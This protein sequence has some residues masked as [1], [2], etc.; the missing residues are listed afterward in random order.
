MRIL[1][2]TAVIVFFSNPAFALA[3]QVSATPRPQLNL[4]QTQAVRE[5][6]ANHAIPLKSVRAGAGFDDLKMLKSVLKNV[7]IVGLG[8]ASHGQREFFQ[9]KHRMLEFL[10][11]R[12][13]F[14]AFGI[15]ASY[16]ACMNINEYV[17][18]GKG[19]PRKALAS[20]GF[21][22][23]DTQ[24]ILDMVE[25]M[26]QY[27]SKLPEAKRIKFLGY[28]MQSQ[29]QY[30]MDAVA[31][32]LKK[33]S[34]DRVTEAET[35]FLPVKAEPGKP[36]NITAQSA[37]DQAKSVARLDKLH[38]FL[39][40]NR[41]KFIEQ[42]SEWDFN[43]VLLHTRVLAQGARYSVAS[44][45]GVRKWQSDKDMKDKSVYSFLGEAIA[46]R[47]L[48]MAENVETQLKMLG[49]KARMVIGGHNAHL[50]VGT[51]GDGNPGMKDLKLP[52]MGG[53]LRK[54]FGDAYYVFGFGFY[55][56][57]FQASGRDEKG[58]SGMQEF[59]MP[60]ASEG[61]VEWHM[62]TAVQEKGFQNYLVNFRAAPKKGLVAEWFSSPL[63]MTT[64]P[65]AFSKD[66]TREDSQAFISLREYFDG[67]LFVEETTRAR[68]NA[69]S[70]GK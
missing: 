63:P 58:V 24:E 43:V 28:D 59:L 61:S 13:R 52:A 12:M 14:T 46:M 29:Y 18:D 51:W 9:F 5:W 70:T 36:L 55:R 20:Q 64:L 2:L 7:R 41:S 23:F 57:S 62:R 68:P 1:I 22:V 30:A 26:R 60:P 19:D 45:K 4:V 35:A 56:G 49:H 27:N 15:E 17:V 6:L 67:M 31:V 44:W 10:V 34:P 42:T 38:A 50:Q 37:E 21:S 69:S 40:T 33:V 8:E 53:Y 65:G 32:Y 16:P 48:Y 54:T 66:R 25:W 47:D 39:V 3:Q 11:T